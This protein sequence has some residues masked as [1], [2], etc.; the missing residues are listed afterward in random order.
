MKGLKAISLVFF[1]LIQIVSHGV[2]EQI[3]SPNDEIALEPLNKIFQSGNNSSSNNTG[4]NNTTNAPEQECLDVVARYDCHSTASV[5]AVHADEDA[6]ST[7]SCFPRSLSATTKYTLHK[8][9]SSKKY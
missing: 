4:G 8:N 6:S 1:L 5:T 9:G 2:H 7:Q 3:H